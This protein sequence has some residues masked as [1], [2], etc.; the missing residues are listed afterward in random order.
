MLKDALAGSDGPYP[1]VASLPHR[2]YPPLAGIER[3]EPAGGVGRQ[4]S[5]TGSSNTHILG[6]DN[7]ACYM[8]HIMRRCVRT[9]RLLLGFGWLFVGPY[10][11]RGVGETEDRTTGTRIRTVRWIESLWEGANTTTREEDQKEEVL[12]VFRD[13]ARES[14]SGAEIREYVPWQPLW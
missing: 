8:A 4:R 7:V 1:D 13:L 3:T 6:Q 12:S 9:A 10:G 5:P 11:G 2:Q 14:R